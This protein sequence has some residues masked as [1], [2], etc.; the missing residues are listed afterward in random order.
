MILRVGR[1][2]AVHEF[3]ERTRDRWVLVISLLFA[4]MAS[5]VTLYGRAAEETAAMLT[6][7]SLVTLASLLVPLVALVLGHDCICGERD[8]NTLGLLLSLPA[9]ASE[10]LV[11]KIVGRFAA[12]AVSVTLGLGAALVLV[13]AAGRASLLLLFGPTLLLG[14]SFLVLGVFFSVVTS[15]PST[16]A[17]LAVAAWFLFVFFYDIG[18]LGALVL[19]D[20]GIPSGVIA[21]LVAS[22]PAGLY[23]VEMMALF[24]GPSGFEDLGLA[25]MLPGRAAAALVWFLWIAGLTAATSVLLARR[26]SH[27]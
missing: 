18:L 24:S 25:S 10:L 9:G 12:L 21:G 23:R 8:R 14:A 6:G 17:S 2:L 13:D 15:R 1:A 27:R 11:A 20:G 5:G 3:L 26:K 7:P 16:S 4:L 22:N 19:T